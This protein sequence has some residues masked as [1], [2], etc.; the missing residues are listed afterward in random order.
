MSWTDG[1]LVLDRLTVCFFFWAPVSLLIRL[2][3]FGGVV[4]G[5]Y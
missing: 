1:S 4:G 2:N 5:S 3:V